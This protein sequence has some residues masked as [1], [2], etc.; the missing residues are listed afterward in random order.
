MAIKTVLATGQTA[1][2]VLDDYRW[3]R[4]PGSELP[5]LIGSADELRELEEMCEP[6]RVNGA[7]NLALARRLDVAGWFGASAPKGA[8]TWPK[9][10]LAPQ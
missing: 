1:V 8:K 6:P 3:N 9:V 10:S 4:K 7:E 2:Q 5:F